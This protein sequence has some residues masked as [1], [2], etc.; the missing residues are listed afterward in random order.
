[1]PFDEAPTG[2]EPAL[3]GARSR[4]DSPALGVDASLAAARCAFD[5]EQDGA[6]WRAARLLARS[7][8]R[9]VPIA[10]TALAHDDYRV[11]AVAA[12]ALRKL[13]A[14]ATHD[15]VP[16][17]ISA[18]ADAHVSVRMNAA[19]ALKAIAARQPDTATQITPALQGY[20]SRRP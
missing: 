7:G 17:L 4:P 10:A 11:R 12:W 19:A 9:A 2:R 5:S 8:A 18:L 15:V 16:L 14:S 6:I 20:R 13:A 1:M 3:G